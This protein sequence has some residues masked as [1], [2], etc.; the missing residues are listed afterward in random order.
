VLIRT[1]LR[2]LPALATPL[3]LALGVFDGVHVGHQAVI[4]QAVAAAAAGGGLAGV[5][6]FDPPPACVLG[7]QPGPGA[8]LATLE[9]KARIVAKCGVGLFI[10][11]RFDAAF[12][13]MEATEFL[14]LLLVAPIHTIAVGEDWRFG[15]DRRGDADLLRQ[16]TASAGIALAAVPTV[17]MDGERV[18]STRIRQAIRDGS[19]AAAA[20]MLGRPYSL[21]GI[22]TEGR[23][24]ARKLGFPTANVAIGA[25]LAPPD[26]VWA[27]RVSIAG[28]E[29]RP[30]IANL[31]VRPTVDGSVRVLEVHLYDFS[32]D[33][34]GREIEVEFVHYQR[35]EMKFES[36]D[37][38]GAQIAEDVRQVR[39]WL[40]P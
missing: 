27:V 14:D 18:S 36:L 40:E 33:L 26:G 19:L 25:V 21:S 28:G 2:E 31:G 6:T 11:L 34:Y 1:E 32:G 20:R 13:L 10:P 22:V 24:L 5:L 15:R 35:P 30:G 16:R 37:L 12:A 29:P 39:Q 38:L 17:M 9:H 23:K 7:P 3:H 8:L 4:G